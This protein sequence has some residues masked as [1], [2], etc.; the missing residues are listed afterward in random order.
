MKTIIN[1]GKSITLLLVLILAIMGC[2]KDSL[3]NDTKYIDKCWTIIDSAT[4]NPIP[5]ARLTI[6]FN[7]PD[8]EL[9]P[10]LKEANTDIN[11]EACAS[12][13]KE[14]YIISGSAIA[15]GYKVNNFNYGN[16]P[17]IIQLLPLNN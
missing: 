14:Y 4:K 6:I 3:D 17:D 11:G 12:F 10:F 7:W 9:G 2:S 5:D 15:S 8:A 1:S 13:V 16:V